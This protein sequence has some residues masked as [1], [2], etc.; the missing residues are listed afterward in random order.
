MTMRKELITLVFHESKIDISL[1]IF[2]KIIITFYNYRRSHGRRF[3]L[4]TNES[5]FIFFEME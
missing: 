5:Q 1:T 2:G 3:E 4:T